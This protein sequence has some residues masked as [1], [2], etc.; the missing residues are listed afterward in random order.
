MSSPYGRL[1]SSSGPY[2]YENEADATPDRA[3]PVGRALFRDADSN[4]S[5]VGR[6]LFRDADAGGLSEVDSEPG[7]PDWMRRR[8]TVDSEPGTPATVASSLL[9]DSRDEIEPD[10]SPAMQRSMGRSYVPSAPSKRFRPRDMA[11]EDDRIDEDLADA[12]TRATPARSFL[13]RV[14]DERDG[15][16]AAT[17]KSLFD[18]DKARDQTDYDALIA[19]PSDDQ[20]PVR[21]LFPYGTMPIRD[22]LVLDEG[23]PCQ[24]TQWTRDD[25]LVTKVFVNPNRRRDNA[26]VEEYN[27]MMRARR[28]FDPEQRIVKLDRV[29]LTSISD[30]QARMMRE[31]GISLG[32]MS[33]RDARRWNRSIVDLPLILSPKVGTSLS[34]LMQTSRLVCETAVNHI[35]RLLVPFVENLALVGARSNMFHNDVTALNICYSQLDDKLYLIDFELMA[36][37]DSDVE[38][39]LVKLFRSVLLDAEEGLFGLMSSTQQAYLNRCRALP[40][41]QVT[42]DRLVRILETLVRL[43]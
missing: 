8:Q 18:S 16:L 34:E 14:A 1:I 12:E 7:T 36:P 23:V 26:A 3:A 5:P 17:R 32:N 25:S 19:A 15:S 10:G 13:S 20:V 30:E 39:D 35:L 29:Y 22:I 31:R 4:V 9:G 33:E 37:R 24:E 40:N 41:E 42:K 21:I 11:V 6:A 28:D 2:R 38:R 27:A 43:K